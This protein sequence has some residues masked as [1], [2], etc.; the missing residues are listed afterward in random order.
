M[1]LPGVSFTSQRHPIVRF[2]LHLKLWSKPSI[3]DAEITAIV[4][5]QIFWVALV[6][7]LAFTM[8]DFTTALVVI[9]CVDMVGRLLGV[10]SRYLFVPIW[11]LAF[12]ASFLFEGYSRI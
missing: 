4:L 6:L 12:S 10:K 1:I 11:I 5:G 9:G 8:P 3:D 7:V 2:C